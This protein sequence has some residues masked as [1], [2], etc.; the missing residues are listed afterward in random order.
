MR[1]LTGLRAAP[2]KTEKLQRNNRASEA[3]A[4]RQAA[5]LYLPANGF[6]KKRVGDS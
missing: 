4:E 1:P 3:S 2:Y 5:S 6:L